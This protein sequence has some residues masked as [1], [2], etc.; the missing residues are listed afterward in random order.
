MA[1]IKDFRELKCWHEARAI[2]KDVYGVV[3]RGDFAK[4]FGLRDQ[5]QRAA[6]LHDASAC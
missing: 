4:D 1:T 6:A 5:I 2:A 3:R